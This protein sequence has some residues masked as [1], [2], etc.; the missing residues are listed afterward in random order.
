MDYQESHKRLLAAQTLLMETTTTRE[1]FSQI[2]TLIKGIHPGIDSSLEQCDKQISDF[3]KLYGGQVIDLVVEHLPEVTEEQ[4]RRKKY[5]VLFWES[6]NKLKGEIARVDAEMNASQNSPD[7]SNKASHWG[8]IAKSAA[9][10]F[11]IITV[12]AVAIVITMQ[13]IGVTLTIN[14]NGCPAFQ[15]TGSTI[16]LPGLYLPNGTIES[17]SSVLATVPP[18]SVKVDGTTASTLTLK[19]LMFNASFQLPGNIS[20]VTIDG[21]SLLNTKQTIPLSNSKQHT[22]VLSCK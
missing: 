6:W 16:A 18:L 2:R 10:P 15:A 20:D 1:K 7:I 4:K 14:N 5:L 21:I 12:I 9:G 17:G 19:A 8:R 13:Q 3:E 11:G 22:L